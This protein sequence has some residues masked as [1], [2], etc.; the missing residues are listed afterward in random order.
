MQP[1]FHRFWQ[2]WNP[3]ISYFFYKAYIHLGGN[4][5]RI[6]L[7]IVVFSLD[8]W[9]HNIIAYPF[10]R[11]WSY[12]LPITFTIFGFLVVVSRELDQFVQWSR[13][14]WVLHLILN[15]G[16]VLAS[17]HMGFTLDALL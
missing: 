8:G 4:T 11:K 3:G 14:P 6:I 12:V 17:F 13:V 1:G 10:L 5:H 7:T 2:V 9:I 16:L 15:L